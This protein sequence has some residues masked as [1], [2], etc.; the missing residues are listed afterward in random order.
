GGTTTDV[1]ALVNDFPRESAVAVEIGGVKTN[2]R[3]PDLISIGLGGGSIVSE[4]NGGVTVGP[5]SVGYDLTSQAL[6]FGGETTT[7][8]DVAIAL[9]RASF[10]STVP[11]LND[12]FIASVEATMTE[13]VEQIV[14]E[15]KTSPDDVP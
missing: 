6:C 10:G 3:M 11:D 7:A 9:G 14:D 4:D 8:T 13:Q 1:G 15:M 2:F 12:D 5:N